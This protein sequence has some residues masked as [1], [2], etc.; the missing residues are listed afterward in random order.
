MKSEEDVA[1]LLANLA[2]AKWVEEMRLHFQRTGSYRP[3]DLARLLGDQ[4]QGVSSVA[5]IATL[6]ANRMR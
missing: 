6:L 5:D 4:R 2:P 3:T 1:A